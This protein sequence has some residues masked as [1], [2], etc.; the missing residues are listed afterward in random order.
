MIKELIAKAIGDGMPLSQKIREYYE[1]HGY[2][3]QPENI[4]AIRNTDKKNDNTFS[5]CI[6]MVTDTEVFACIATTVPGTTWTKERL[7]AKGISTTG[8]YCLGHYV[9]LWT[10]GEH[11]G[12]AFMQVGKCSWYEDK[13]LNKK[14]DTGDIIYHDAYC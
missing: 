7:K 9:G 5:D 1:K 8:Q 12:R 11:Q 14:Q 13:N 4:I 6:A 10:F 3:W 2:E